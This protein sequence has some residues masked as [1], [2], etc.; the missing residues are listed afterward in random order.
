MHLCARL[1]ACIRCH[2]VTEC[3]VVGCSWSV[4]RLPADYT[5]AASFRQA[6]VGQSSKSSG[7]YIA[8]LARW[9]LIMPCRNGTNNVRQ[10]CQTTKVRQGQCSERTAHSEN[11]SLNRLDA[12]AGGEVF[13][14]LCLCL[15]LCRSFQLERNG[16]C[17]VC[18]RPA[19]AQRRCRCGRRR[20]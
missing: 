19:G 18:S 1:I 13:S 11:R 7:S 5:S 14:V 2:Q 20:R 9:L 10:H 15:R 16:T 4:G 12:K 8:A 3:V 17:I 6:L